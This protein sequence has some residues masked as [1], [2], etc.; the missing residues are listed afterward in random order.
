M[1]ELRRAVEEGLRIGAVTRDAIAQ[2]LQPREEW[3]LTL[4]TLDG[5]P[6]LRHVRVATASVHEYGELLATGGVR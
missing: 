1:A 5:H 3:R 4:F 2:F 6:H